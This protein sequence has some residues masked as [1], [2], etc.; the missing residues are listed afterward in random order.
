MLLAWGRTQRDCKSS[1]RPDA[2]MEP[3]AP[4]HSQTIAVAH[5]QTTA[6]HAAI[7]LA[8][9]DPRANM[10]EAEGGDPAMAAGRRLSYDPLTTTSSKA[11]GCHDVPWSGGPEPMGY[12]PCE[13]NPELSGG[14]PCSYPGCCI[15]NKRYPRAHTHDA[16]VRQGR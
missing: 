3:T 4:A 10:M 15:L 14:G 7:G 5:F 8:R 16:Y 12:P 1:W 13:G 9:R 2:K 11:P 6:R